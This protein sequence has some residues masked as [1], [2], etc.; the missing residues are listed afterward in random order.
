[1]EERI[2]PYSI[3]GGREN[4]NKGRE[5]RERYSA[6]GESLE[7]IGRQGKTLPL[8]GLHEEGRKDREEK[9]NRPKRN[10]VKS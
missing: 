5:G 10:K 3:R 6:R 1:M 7:P 2:T 9:R 8:W 4:N